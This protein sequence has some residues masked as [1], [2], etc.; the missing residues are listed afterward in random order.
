VEGASSNL[1]LPRS[2]P[3]STL[4]LPTPSFLV[5]HCDA[6]MGLGN[7][8]VTFPSESGHSLAPKRIIVV[9]K[10]PIASRD[11]VMTLNDIFAHTF[12]HTFTQTGRIRTKLSR[13]MEI[14]EWK[15][16]TLYSFRQN[17]PRDPGERG[18]Y[19]TIFL[20]EE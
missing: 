20:C 4:F 17:R 15:R 14:V 7:T 8:V 11:I 9:D 12:A 6:A 1:Y 3:Y 13:G 5:P 16:L 18:K 10:K 19:S 2:P